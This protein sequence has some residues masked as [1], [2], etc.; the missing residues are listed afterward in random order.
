MNIQ[1]SDLRPTNPSDLKAI[2]TLE[3]SGYSSETNQ[4]YAT[5]HSDGGPLIFISVPGNLKNVTSLTNKRPLRAD[6][7]STSIKKARLHYTVSKDCS[8]PQD[9]RREQRLSSILVCSKQQP[10]TTAAAYRTTPARDR[11]DRARPA[12]AVPTRIVAQ[13]SSTPAALD[14]RIP[15]TPVRAATGQRRDRGV[16]RWYRPEPSN[17]NVM[18]KRHRHRAR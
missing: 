18:N 13:E 10:R 1:S 16:S 17:M 11:S 3:D 15:A 6:A 14:S 9:I 4:P 5:D 12:A 7:N 8:K 2:S